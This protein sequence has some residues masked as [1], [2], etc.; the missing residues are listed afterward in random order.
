[1][2]NSYYEFDK[3]V[4]WFKAVGTSVSNTSIGSSRCIDTVFEQTLANPGDTVHALFGG[5]FLVRKDGSVEEGRFRL[6][7]HIF[8]KTYGPPELDTDILERLAKRGACHQVP[9]PANRVDY[10]APRKAVAA[11]R[12]PDCTGITTPENY[13]ETPLMAELVAFAQGEG[14]MDAVKA[15]GGTVTKA[16]VGQGADPERLDCYLHVRVPEGV[17]LDVSAAPDRAGY[18]VSEAGENGFIAALAEAGGGGMSPD[19]RS[20]RFASFPAGQGEAMIRALSAYVADGHVNAPAA[21]GR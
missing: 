10:G 5:S 14:L 15:A 17:R 8:L 11:R 7:K 1:M 4:R 12:F 16:D 20:A 3:P 19:I 13:A 21:P 6:P 2:G 18:F 9:A